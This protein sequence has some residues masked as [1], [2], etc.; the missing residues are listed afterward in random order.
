MKSDQRVLGAPERVGWLVHSRGLRFKRW[1]IK[2]GFF[3]KEGPLAMGLK[4]DT[5]FNRQNVE[6]M[7]QKFFSPFP[8]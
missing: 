6:K 5:D 7:L 1:R 8:W 2:N 3:V 4:D